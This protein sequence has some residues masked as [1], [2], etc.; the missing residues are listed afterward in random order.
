MWLRADPGL[1][2]L[3]AQN[4]DG[5]GGTARIGRMRHAVLYRDLGEVEGADTL[6]AGDVHPVF[7]GVRA[8]LV[9]GVDAAV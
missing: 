3:E 2:G 5:A 6:Q 7:P 4:A 1:C 8:A 9:V